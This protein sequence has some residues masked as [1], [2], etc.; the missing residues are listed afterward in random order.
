VEEGGA[1]LLIADHMPFPGAA[2]ELWQAFGI[3]TVNGYAARR[4]GE[5]IVFEAGDNLKQHAITEGIDVVQS[6][7][8]QGFRAVAEVEPLMVLPEGTVI[9]MTTTAGKFKGVAEVTGDYLLQGA[10]AERGQGRV[11]FFGEAAMFSAQKIRRDGTEITFGMNAPGA[12]SNVLF[13]RRV[14]AWL[15]GAESLPES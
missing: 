13:L 2:G 10:V 15:S 3:Y 5:P 4:D 11:A 14:L 1:L 6:F 9:R 12:E 7:T 8:G